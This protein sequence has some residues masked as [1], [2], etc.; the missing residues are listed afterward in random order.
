MVEAENARR[1]AG[2]RRA[3]KEIEGDEPEE[4]PEGATDEPG[5]RAASIGVSKMGRALQWGTIAVNSGG[6][7]ITA[8]TKSDAVSHR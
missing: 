6:S 2:K 1:T 4:N 8:A 7:I 5:R 3:T